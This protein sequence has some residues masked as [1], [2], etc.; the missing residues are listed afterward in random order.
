MARKPELTPGGVDGLITQYEFQA[1]VNVL[2]NDTRWTWHLWT[3]YY[4]RCLNELMNEGL[5]RNE[6]VNKLNPTN[7]RVKKHFNIEN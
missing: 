6:A 7:K 3:N 5:D 1:S 4:N 2:K